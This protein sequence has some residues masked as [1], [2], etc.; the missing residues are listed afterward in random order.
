M[1]REE[2]QIISVCQ[3]FAIV[4][5]Y[6]RYEVINSGHINTTYRVYLYATGKKRITFYKR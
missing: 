5:E 6:S 2:Q 4:G 1:N 3:R